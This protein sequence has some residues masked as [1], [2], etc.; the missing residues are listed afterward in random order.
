[1]LRK[2]LA[3]ILLASISVF[4]N[5][6]FILKVS[7]RFSE[8]LETLEILKINN[9]SRNGTKKFSINHLTDSFIQNI[10]NKT[11]ELKSQNFNYILNPKEACGLRNGSD[12]LFVALIP[13]SP[14]NFKQRMF[15]RNSWSNSEY[16]SNIK[17]VFLTGLSGSNEIN[18]KLHHEFELFSDIIQENF[19]DT[20][21]NLTLKTLMGFKW[22]SQYCSNAKFI[23]KVDDDVVVNTVYLV[24]YLSQ[25]LLKNDKM[26]NTLIC[27]FYKKAH[28]FRNKDSKFYLSK[29][30]FKPDF[31]QPYCDGPA[32]LLTTDLA[33]SFYNES[34]NVKLFQFED[35]Y[36]GMLAANLNS[37]FINIERQYALNTLTTSFNASLA[38]EQFSFIYLKNRKEFINIWLSLF[39]RILIYLY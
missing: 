11:V 16:F 9:S 35:V 18:E 14:E 13:I 30:E 4:V 38:Y 26:N 23:L 36:V 5:T 24:N 12:L 29:E 2:K 15:I 33:A 22:V 8:P 39:K 20:Y 31:F 19:L 37:T 34:A 3:I 6:I 1:M 25:E 32:Y 28:V 7:I 27:H 10:T 21:K 17:A